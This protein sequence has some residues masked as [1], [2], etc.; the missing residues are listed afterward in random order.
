MRIIWIHDVPC[1]GIRIG[2]RVPPL[3]YAPVSTNTLTLSVFERTP[4][5]G[6][7]RAVGMKRRQVKA[8]IR[9]EAVIIALFGA[10][11]GI[12]VG[13]GLGIALA[14]ALRNNGVTNIAVPLGSMIL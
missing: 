4:Q 9:S 5:T 2:P 14:S 13:T 1:G 3:Y 6:L 7:L 12:I 8:M 10:V 11:V